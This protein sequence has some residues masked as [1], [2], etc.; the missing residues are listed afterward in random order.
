MYSRFMPSTINKPTIASLVWKSNSGVHLPQGKVIQQLGYNHSFFK[1]DK[2]IPSNADIILIQGP[3]GSLLPFFSQYREIP[4]NEKP[5]LIYWF[6][7]NLYIAMPLWLQYFFGVVYSGAYST[8]E[9]NPFSHTLN[10]LL[11]KFKPNRGSRFATLGDILWLDRNNLLNILATPASEYQKVFAGFGI[12]SLLI[13]RGYHPDYGEIRDLTRD[14]AVLWM[15][16]IRTERRERIIHGLRVELANEGLEMQVYDGIEKPFIFGEERTSLLNRSWFI[17]NILAYPTDEISIRYYIAAANGA[18][19]LTEPGK[20]EYPFE[21][22]AHLVECLPQQMAE[23]VSYHIN[24]PEEWQRISQNAFNLVSQEL[25][26]ENSISAMLTK[27][28]KIINKK[29]NVNP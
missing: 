29:C 13:P 1:Y 9:P 11:N 14:I 19:I 22:W 18:V 7:Q 12:D 27:A 3:Y 21:N 25:T 4:E 16:K 17:L 23:T 26:L 10:I 15:G 2:P 5:I 24:H 6:Q 20:N 8:F 28:E